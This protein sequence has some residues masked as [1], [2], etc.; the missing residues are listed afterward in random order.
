MASLPGGLSLRLL[1]LAVLALVSLRFIYRTL[2]SRLR[3]RKMTQEHGCQPA[4]QYQHEGILGKTLGLDV[5]RAM[6]KASKEH[7]GNEAA[8]ERFFMGGHN[9]VQFHLLGKTCNDDI[10]H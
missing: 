3:R 7:R 5:M 2:T 4:Y 9:T 8:R 10:T 6:S 1:S